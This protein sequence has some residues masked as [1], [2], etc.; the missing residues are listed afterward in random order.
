M[1]KIFIALAFAGITAVAMPDAASAK[2][3]KGAPGIKI[4][5]GS[6][7]IGIGIGLGTPHIHHRHYC[8]D[9]NYGCF[10]DYTCYRWFDP[11]RGCYVYFFPGY[12]NYYV[13]DA[14][15]L[16]FVPLVAVPLDAAVVTGPV[17]PL[18]PGLAT[19]GVPPMSIAPMP[20][21]P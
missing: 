14:L 6:P 4:G 15:A 18:P 1:N 19:T 10:Y 11:V 8:V 13:Y 16:R 3:P 2:G 17:L 5:F 12:A 9:W 20:V 7:K 21:L